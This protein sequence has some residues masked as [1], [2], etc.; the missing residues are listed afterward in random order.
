MKISY[1]SDALSVPT[2]GQMT[3]SAQAIEVA[4][5]ASAIKEGGLGETGAGG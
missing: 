3:E 1:P 2:L 4:L 5:Q